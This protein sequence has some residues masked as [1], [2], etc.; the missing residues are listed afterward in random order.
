M[1]FRL[2]AFLL[3]CCLSAGS[4]HGAEDGRQ[5]EKKPGFLGRMTRSLNPFRSKGPTDKLNESKAPNWKDLELSMALDPLPLKLPETRLLKVTLRLAN[6]SKKFVQMEF[7]TSQRIEVLIRNKAGKLVEQWSED[8]AFA[9]EPTL[10]VVNPRERLEYSVSVATRDLVAGET[11]VLEA[12]FP[13]Y[14]P[15]RIQ[16]SIVPER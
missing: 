14:E 13:N 4:L 8:Q 3:L 11:Y 9:N 10:V 2:P 16:K 6:Q 5:E 7:P 15:L 1:K 12:F